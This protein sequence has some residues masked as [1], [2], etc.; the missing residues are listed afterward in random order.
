MGRGRPKGWGRCG[1]E[2]TREREQR[3]REASTRGEVG[4]QSKK[5]AGQGV[6]RG[7]H[8]PAKSA[9]QHVRGVRRGRKLPVQ[10]HVSQRFLLIL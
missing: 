2:P 3:G 5:E 4:A 7:D 10:S 8:L 6:R 1:D 9:S